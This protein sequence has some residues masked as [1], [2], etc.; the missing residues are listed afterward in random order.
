MLQSGITKNGNPKVNY[1]TVFQVD[2]K[3]RFVKCNL[4][5][6]N[7]TREGEPT[8]YSNWFATFLGGDL[9][10]AKTLQDKD[11]IVIKDWKIEKREYEKNGQRQWAYDVVIYQFDKQE[12]N[13][14]S[15]DE[16]PI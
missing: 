15:D 14:E 1:G 4:S 9:A 12:N 6:K 8:K 3:D 5:T 10:K 7:Y 16:E 2:V 13:Y 11:H